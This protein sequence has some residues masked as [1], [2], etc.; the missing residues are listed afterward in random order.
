MVS[1][2]DF[3]KSARHRAQPAFHARLSHDLCL[4]EH[5]DLRD[6]S[7]EPHP[8][9]SPRSRQAHRPV[10]DQAAPGVAPLCRPPRRPPL[11][12]TLRI[13]LSQAPGFAP[14]IVC[15]CLV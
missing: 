11:K 8:P 12:L 3:D 6:P 15:A 4:A 14:D 13:L 1:E 10:R 5:G 9:R 2:V 7:H